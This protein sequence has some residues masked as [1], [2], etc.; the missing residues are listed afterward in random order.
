MKTFLLCFGVIFACTTWSQTTALPTI[1]IHGETFL[2]YP[3]QQNVSVHWKENLGQYPCFRYQNENGSYSKGKQLPKRTKHYNA[4]LASFEYDYLNEVNNANHLMEIIEFPS[5][6]FPDGNYVMLYDSVLV[7]HNDTL[8]I[9][10][11]QV[12]A[13]FQRKGNRVEG[14]VTFFYTTGDTLATGTVKNGLKQ[15]TWFIYHKYWIG[16][17]NGQQ[18]EVTKFELNYSDNEFHGPQKV[19]YQSKLSGKSQLEYGEY[20]HGNL[21]G[22]YGVQEDGITKTQGS[23]CNNVPCGPWVNSNHNGLFK[24]NCSQQSFLESNK[25]IAFP[26][27][28]VKNG[29]YLQVID[30]V[31]VPNQFDDQPFV[32]VNNFAPFQDFEDLTPFFFVPRLKGYSFPDAYFG[33]SE[34][35]PLYYEN[36]SVEAEVMD[37]TNAP[38]SYE[39]YKN[40]AGYVSLLS[41]PC[42]FYY[43]NG[44]LKCLIDFSSWESIHNFQVFYPNGQLK[45]EMF[46]KNDLLEYKNYDTLGHVMCWKQRAKNETVEK[47]L[48]HPDRIVWNAKTYMKY[49]NWAW[50]TDTIIS[51][52]NKDQLFS[53]RLSPVDS[54]IIEQTWY[55]PITK[56][57]SYWKRTSE[58]VKISGVFQLTDDLLE[59]QVWDTIRYNNYWRSALINESLDSN[60]YFKYY[61]ERRFSEANCSTA[62]AFGS[63]NQRANY[64]PLQV[65]NEEF[66][67]QLTIVLKD[68]A[69]RFKQKDG[70]VEVIHWAEYGNLLETLFGLK[71]ADVLNRY[72]EDYYVDL[73]SFNDRFA[74]KI[75]V[76]VTYRL[77]QID[78]K[79]AFFLDGKC[80]NKWTYEMG[81]KN[82]PFAYH[83]FREE[84][85]MGEYVKGKKEGPFVLKDEVGNLLTKGF[86]VHDKITGNPILE[87]YDGERVTRSYFNQNQLDSVVTIDTEFNQ[88]IQRTNL[89]SGEEWSYFDTGICNRYRKIVDKDTIRVTHFSDGMIVQ[90]SEYAANGYRWI[91]RYK[92][93]IRT[94]RYESD[95]T[96]HI[97]LFEDDVDRL[98]Q[99]PEGFW[100]YKNKCYLGKMTGWTTHFINGAK[101][102]E[103]YFFQG[104]QI[105]R[106]SYFNHD[107]L[108]AQLHFDTVP[109]DLN[110]I[111]STVYSIST[112]T[113][114]MQSEQGRFIDFQNEYDCS[115]G[116]YHDLYLFIPDRLDTLFY[117]KNYFPNGKLMNEGWIRN[118][119]PDGMWRW[120]HHDG[121][122]WA[123]GSY[124]HGKRDGLWM[125][126]DLEKMRYLA[127]KCVTDP[128]SY[129][130]LANV[131]EVQKLVYQMGKLTNKMELNIN[132]VKGN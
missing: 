18:S 130:K 65:N 13:I 128:V 50:T 118:G 26:S 126:G 58:Q 104:D 4:R 132:N 7:L 1:S 99:S 76:S 92:D 72:N 97:I 123:V 120:Y 77:G 85:E 11:K 93:G 117:Q 20:E 15:G 110:Q 22:Q 129:Q 102:S 33:N 35:L 83:N 122:W 52:L 69:K 84:F 105:G 6:Q 24:G 30:G 96:L 127:D 103:G 44:Q 88:V 57:G 90:K 51:N 80:W 12:F 108:V 49:N 78:K 101:Y 111:I 42:S 39:E 68:N 53:E 23:F 3:Y 17:I 29:R 124:I 55:N 115:D 131:L 56:R 79:L 36:L 71:D 46:T 31:Y 66:S 41:G 54:S 82:G 113:M 28:V 9:S 27:F 114:K 37:S 34:R 38:L 74:E 60:Q 89:K 25:P 62:I 116:N 95:T 59:H 21:V 86:Y 10:D 119:A 91:E 47:D 61:K 87:E 19:S 106:W 2:V 63:D 94:H 109:N 16:G 48:L 67:G 14:K 40:R 121:S 45:F 73:Y 112:G 98:I 107:T 125:L 43:P 32:H 70:K 5:D 8:S 81:I 100:N 75:T 64:G